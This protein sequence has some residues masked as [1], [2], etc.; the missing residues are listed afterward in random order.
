MINGQLSQPPLSR[1]VNSRS[2]PPTPAMRSPVQLANPASE[3]GANRE[4]LINAQ[5]A[6]LDRFPLGVT[7]KNGFTRSPSWHPLNSDE[8]ALAVVTLVPR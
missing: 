5:A 3:G 2:S 6:A 4:S 7:E 8:I 1:E